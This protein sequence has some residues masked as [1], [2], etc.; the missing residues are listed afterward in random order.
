VRVLV[1]DLIALAADLGVLDLPDG[2][3]YPLLTVYSFRLRIASA[4]TVERATVGKL[5]RVLV[6]MD[7]DQATAEGLLRTD[8]PYVTAV[9]PNENIRDVASAK[10]AWRSL[11]AAELVAAALGQ[12]VEVR[13]SPGNARPGVVTRA[14]A[15]YGVPALVW[16]F[17]AVEDRLRVVEVGPT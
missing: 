10:S 5:Q 3:E 13:L 11:P 8:S 16:A 4:L 9:D 1:D 7:V 17:E 12:D 15:A 14:L 6:E 2:V